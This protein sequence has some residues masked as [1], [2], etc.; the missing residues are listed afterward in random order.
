MRGEYDFSKG[1]RGLLYGKVK[2]RKSHVP[3][4]IHFSVNQHPLCNSKPQAPAL[5]TDTD[6]VTCKSCLR[7]L[8][9]PAARAA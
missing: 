2:L 6:E 4:V 5:S 9:S 8:E 1:V 3:K 7:K